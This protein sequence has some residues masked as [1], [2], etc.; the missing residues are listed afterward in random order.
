M[1]KTLIAMGILVLL[2]T[3]CESSNNSKKLSKTNMI[4]PTMQDEVSEDALWVGTFQLV[5]NDLK[6]EIVQQDIEIDHQFARNLNQELYTEEDLSSEYYYKKYGKASLEL[7]AEIEKGIKEKFNQ[8]SAILDQLDWTADYIFY[9]MLYREFEFENKFDVL[10]NNDFGIYKNIRYFGIGPDSNDKL[11][12]QIRIL[13][14]ENN[15]NFAISIKT[16]NG[17]EV[18]MYKN[19]EGNTFEEMYDNL[20]QKMAEYTGTTFFGDNDEFKSPII[21][22]NYLRE[23]EE[24][25]NKPFNTADGKEMLIS[26][27]LQTIEFLLDEKGGK[28]KSEA[29]IGVK[30]TAMPNEEE[31]K[32]LY[33]NDT[34]TLFLKE[35]SKDKPYLAAKITDI[36]KFQ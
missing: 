6:N 23:Y 1:K 22:V 13:F 27:A 7:K 36:T 25:K 19:P 18:I 11:G 3:G 2:L 16:K 35:E 30:E 34:F 26:D 14:Y 28:V 21:S 32:R 9:T 10:S 12:K 24:L 5:W 4:V 31:P 8:T 17:D 20:N 29:A 15:Q 33:L